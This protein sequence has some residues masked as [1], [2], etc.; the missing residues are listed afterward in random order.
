MKRTSPLV[1][2]LTF[3]AC[4][5]AAAPPVPVETGLASAKGD[6]VST[7]ATVLPTFGGGGAAEAINDA[8]TVVGLAAEANPSRNVV[9]PH[10]P[11]KWA[12]DG[13]GVWVVTKLGTAGGRALGLNEA[14]D[15]VGYGG[16]QAIIW[17]AVGVAPPLGTGFANG[18]NAARIIVGASTLGGGPSTVAYVWVPSNTSPTTWTQQTLPLLEAG[19]AATAVAINENS[20][21]AGQATR[22]G[23]YKAVIWLPENGGWSAPIPREGTEASTRSSGAFAINDDGDVVGYVCAG[24][25]QSCGAHPFVWR[26]TGGSIDL[27]SLNPNVSTGRAFGIANR[28]PNGGQVVGSVS[29]TKGI[30]GGPF[31][32]YPE[33]TT[34][35][36]LGDGEAKGINNGTGQYR[37][38]AVGVMSSSSGQRAL[39]WRIP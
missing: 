39:V 27:A 28:G 20:V 29:V 25:T 5:D 30:G 21:I 8:G 6:A 16:G 11:V 4:T 32:W 36:D 1:A 38:E 13:N 15:V 35:T 23:V 3:V 18:I 12:R 37:Q 10:Y 24:A 22:G 26:K 31:L 17:P 19:G 9:G 14:G 7:G 34:L 2:A 33:G